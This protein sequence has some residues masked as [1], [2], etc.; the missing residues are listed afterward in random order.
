MPTAHACDRSQFI[1]LLV[2]SVVCAVAGIE[3]RCRAK[4]KKEE[5]VGWPVA[6]LS[7][8]E[9]GDAVDL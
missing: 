9:S 2:C 3:M 6:D 8:S 4:G 1:R 7:H 5:Q